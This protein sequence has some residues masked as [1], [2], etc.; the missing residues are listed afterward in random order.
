MHD[1]SLVSCF[2]RQQVNKNHIT[3]GVARGNC[4][5]PLRK[6]CSQSICLFV[7]A[8]NEPIA[9]LH[10]STSGTLPIRNTV[11]NHQLSQHQFGSS[12]HLK[13]VSHYSICMQL[14]SYS[15]FLFC[16]VRFAYVLYLCLFFRKAVLIF[17]LPR[18]GA[19]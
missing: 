2:V 11:T 9:V 7:K 16:Y 13:N 10:Q 15:L 5:I 17:Q 3:T 8:A 4:L 14:L 19:K 6:I 12:H 1:S 18:G